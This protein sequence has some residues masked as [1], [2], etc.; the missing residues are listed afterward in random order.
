MRENISR[1]LSIRRLLL[2]YKPDIFVSFLTYNNVLAAI[3]AKWTD[4]HTVIA[5]R[6]AAEF[7]SNKLWR[8]LRRVCYPLASVLVTQTVADATY[9]R[10]FMNVKV[11]AN[12]ISFDCSGCAGVEKRPNAT[13]LAV[14][15][16]EHQK[17]FDTLLKAVAKCNTS[18]R[19]TIAGTGAEE[20]TLCEL[21]LEL[22]ITDRVNFA[23]YVAEITNLYHNHRIFVMTSRYEGYPNALLEAMACGCACISTDCPHGP[24]D[25]LKN[26]QNGIL[27]PVD[28]VER[29]SSAIDRL[30]S[31]STTASRMGLA[32]QYTASRHTLSA[33]TNQWDTLFRQICAE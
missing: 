25:L 13:I 33:I 6:I 30:L 7:L 19:L 29:L 12:P 22:G 27:I 16:L 20:R 14:G 10:R 2:A 9:Y 11:I 21:A 1:I 3:A 28:D 31:D 24:Q 17:G 23:G 8:A 18:F 15:R 4:V 32:A 5:E 26:G